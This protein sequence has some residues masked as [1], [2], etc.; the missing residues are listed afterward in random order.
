MKIRL[1]QAVASMQNISR[2]KAQNL[3]KE[4]CVYVDENLQ[5]KPAFEVEDYQNIKVLMA[6]NYVSRGAYKLIKGLDFFGKS[7]EN[8]VVLDMGASTGG[9]TE[10]LLERGVKRVLSVD[11]GKG[12]LDARLA[13]NPNVVNMQGRDIRSLT[14]EEV[15]GVQFVTGDLSFI[16]LSKVLPHILQILPNAQM[17]LLFKPQFECGK[18][19][20]KKYHGVIKDKAVHKSLLQN[21]V[22]SCKKLGVQVSGLT[23][24]PIKG[25]SGNIEYLVYING[26][27]KPFNIE[28]L[29]DEAFKLAK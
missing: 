3:I 9:F 1:D 21:F 4:G 24:S 20:A 16:S 12:E 23:H 5:N 10:V 27:G 6:D 29:V 2:T 7:V 8:L 17:I 18:D 14:K 28:N 11:I 22:E 19:I 15:E 25:G 26:K 13:Q